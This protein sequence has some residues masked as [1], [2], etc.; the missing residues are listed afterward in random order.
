MVAWQRVKQQL[1]IFESSRQGIDPTISLTRIEEKE[2]LNSLDLV[3]L[4]NV[5]NGIALKVPFREGCDNDA[6]R[7]GTPCAQESS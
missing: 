6:K 7:S 3:F 4:H 1:K 2:L 5:T